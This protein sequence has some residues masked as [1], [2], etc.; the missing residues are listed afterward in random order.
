MPLPGEALKVAASDLLDL[1][2]QLAPL[3]QELFQDLV[4]ADGGDM[5]EPTSRGLNLRKRRQAQGQALYC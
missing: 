1:Q 3:S 2:E 4:P 5:A